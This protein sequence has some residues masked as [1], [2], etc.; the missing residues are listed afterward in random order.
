M[1]AIAQP[2]TALAC[3]VCGKPIPATQRAY[4]VTRRNPRTRRFEPGHAHKACLGPA[5]GPGENRAA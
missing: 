5:W 1:T 2:P 3:V 4:P